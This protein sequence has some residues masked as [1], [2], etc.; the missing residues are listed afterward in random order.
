MNLTRRLTLG[1]QLQCLCC[2]WVTKVVW[3]WVAPLHK[4]GI[5]YPNLI[6]KIVTKLSMFFLA[7]LTRYLYLQYYNFNPPTFFPI[8]KSYSIHVLPTLHSNHCTASSCY[9][10]LPPFVFLSADNFFF[11]FIERM[12]ANRRN[13]LILKIIYTH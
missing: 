3:V 2:N 4:M 6:Q 9:S 1:M 8:I 10:N 11:Y 5:I 13:S 7:Y 12:E